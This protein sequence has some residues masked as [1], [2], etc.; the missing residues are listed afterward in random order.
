[1]F[2]QEFAGNFYSW[3]GQIGLLIASVTFSIVSYLL[4]TDKELS[5]LDQR[6][7]LFL[8]A[9]VVLSLGIFMCSAI[10]SL[11]ISGEIEAGTLRHLLLTPVSHFRVGFEKLLFAVSLW[12]MIY[13][14]SIPYLVV[15]AAGTG[16]ELSAVTYVG[17]YGTLLTA[18]VSSISI[19]TSTQFT[20]KGSIMTAVVLALSLLS[21]SLFFSTALL[22]SDF[23][24]LIENIDPFSHAINSLDSVLV[25]N[26]Q[27]LSEQFLH[28]WPVVLFILVSV[29]L[30]ALS[31]RRLEV[32]G[33]V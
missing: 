26:Q 5:L 10:A 12:L 17:L 19:A 28:I 16:L 23:G 21:P 31:T 15:I 14:I 20:S 11:T 4:L 25:D 2:R 33:S 3:R 30:L 6:E 32:K 9:E 1:M 8:V 27:S 24:T 7:A 29:V 13:L 22:K 18:A